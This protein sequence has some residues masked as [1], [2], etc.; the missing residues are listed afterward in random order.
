MTLREAARSCSF[1]G[2]RRLDRIAMILPHIVQEMR[3]SSPI[4]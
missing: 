3:A 2:R 1:G 4:L